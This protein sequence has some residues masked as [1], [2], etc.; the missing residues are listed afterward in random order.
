MIWVQDDALRHPVPCFLLSMRRIKEI[1]CKASGQRKRKSVVHLKCEGSETAIRYLK[2]FL[3]RECNM[4]IVP[5]PSQYAQRIS[6]CRR[7]RLPSG[8]NPGKYLGCSRNTCKRTNTPL[9]I[10]C[11]W[12]CTWHPII[13]HWHARCQNW[14]MLSHV[15]RS[16][17]GLI[18]LHKDSN[19]A[20]TE[21]T[22]HRR[23]YCTSLP[24][25]SGISLHYVHW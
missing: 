21:F 9:M 20:G 12:C 2:K 8:T 18:P 19:K 14:M 22:P 11:G 5:I 13:K 6:W 4:D 15:R 25:T 16:Q 17:G 7:H 23:A 24:G 1:K 10:L 3:D